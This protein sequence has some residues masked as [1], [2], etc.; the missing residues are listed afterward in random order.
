[1]QHAVNIRCAQIYKDQ[2]KNHRFLPSHG[3]NTQLEKA[4]SQDREIDINH[5][6]KKTMIT[7]FNSTNVVQRND[8]GYSEMKNKNM[9]IEPKKISFQL[10]CSQAH[11]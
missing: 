4:N 3:V 10:E 5:M 2:K 8:F 6:Y 9:G 1:M 7:D 11:S